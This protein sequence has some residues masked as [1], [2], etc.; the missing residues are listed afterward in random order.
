MAKQVINVGLTAND[1][2]GDSL[3]SG[4]Q[5]INENFTELYT[6]LGN[7]ATG[8]LSMVSTVRAGPGI[9]I[10]NPSG[11]VTISSRIATP[12]SLGGVKVD[13]TTIFVAEDGTISSSIRTNQLVNGEFAAVLDNG[14]NL[15]LPAG[16]FG[17]SNILATRDTYPV[18]LAYGTRRF[19]GP[20]LAWVES[21]DPELFF[22]SNTNRNSM[23]INYRGVTIEL[24]ANSSSGPSVAWTF[25]PTG[26]ITLPENG[27]IVDPTGQT[28]LGSRYVLPT[29]GVGAGG[30]LG[31]VKVDGTTITITDGIISGTSVY[32]LPTA[33][34][35]TGGTLGGVK[36]DGTTITVTN[37]VISAAGSSGRTMV[38]GTSATLAAGTSG[39]FDITGFKAYTLFKIQTSGA[40]WVTLYT[41][42]A[43]RS[44][45][46]GRLETVDPL[47]GSGVIAEVI[48]TG[49]DIILVSPGVIGF[50]NEDVPTVSIPVKVVNKGVSP[51][52]ITVTLTVLKL[53]N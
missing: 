9:T 25:D 20:E 42:N 50:N 43:A 15:E 18:V 7:P 12:T 28:V 5:K 52:A 26:V 21:N 46:A 1:G 41:N 24:D 48:T 6:F 31:G 38:S 39:T 51:A 30:T 2:T 36:V 3:R 16:T 8:Q 53:E 23:Y 27:D 32:T 35:G 33:G 49:E 10:D 29:A 14:G 11:N 47:P 13:G 40:A 4:A 44:A 45:D 17:T 22:D 34:V 19:G 37:G